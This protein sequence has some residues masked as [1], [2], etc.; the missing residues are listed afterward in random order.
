MAIN[1]T[2][3]GN[4]YHPEWVGLEDGCQPDTGGDGYQPD[5]DGIGR[6]VSTIHGWD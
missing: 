4:G 5:M 6:W 1:Q 2:Q 3:V